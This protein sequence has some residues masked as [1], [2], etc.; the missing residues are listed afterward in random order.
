[1][2]DESMATNANTHFDKY[3]EYAL[4]VYSR[5]HLTAG[6]IAAVAGVPHNQMRV[7]TAGRIRA[8]G[9]DV[10]PSEQHGP[11]HADLPLPDPPTANDWAALQ[12][13]F[14]PPSPNPA[15]KATS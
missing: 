2:T 11:A 4:S 8:A 14:D 13:A 9:Y 6:Q 15:R 5:P 3:G 1:M 10:V 7:S 12:A